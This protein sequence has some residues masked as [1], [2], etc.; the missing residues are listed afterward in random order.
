MWLKV[1]VRTAK[2]NARPQYCSK[3]LLYYVR[4]QAF[5]VVLLNPSFLQKLAPNF[6][7]ERAGLFFKGRNI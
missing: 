4:F 5:A 6:R 2:P 3:A 7:R 1:A